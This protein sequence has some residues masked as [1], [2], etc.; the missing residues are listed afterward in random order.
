MDEHPNV[1]YR[2]FFY[3]NGKIMKGLSELQFDGEKTWPLQEE[4]R[5]DAKTALNAEEGKYFYAY[6]DWSS[7]EKLMKKFPDFLDYIKTLE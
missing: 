2:Y 1:N 5:N 7:S 6:K 4:G 3:E